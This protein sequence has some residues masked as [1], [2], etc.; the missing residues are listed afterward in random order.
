M[1]RQPSRL[2]S[3]ADTRRRLVDAAARVFARQGLAGATTRA[4]AEEAG[5]NEVTLFRHFQTKDRLLAAVVG[6]SF[7]ADA[8][9]GTDAPPPATPDLRSDLLGHARRYEKLL[10][11]NLPLV[12]TMVG[13]IQHRHRDHEKQVFRGIFRPVKAALL[14]RLEAAQNAGALRSDIS[15]P[16]L[17]DLFGSMIFMGVLRRAVPDL[18]LEYSENTHLEAAVDLVMRGAGT[19]SVRPVAPP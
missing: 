6:Q 3:P 5:V 18:K 7:G 12:R 19:E 13:E 2:P 10:K 8:A 11:Q 14:A 1:Q 4:I 17:A 9:T 15:G 16:L